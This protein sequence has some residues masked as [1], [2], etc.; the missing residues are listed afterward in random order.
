MDKKIDY[1]D[2]AMPI[3]STTYQCLTCFTRIEEIHD[4]E[5][6]VRVIHPA[7][8]VKPMHGRMRSPFNLLGLRNN[9]MYWFEETGALTLMDSLDEKLAEMSHVS[10]TVGE[11]LKVVLANMN[12]RKF[13]SS[14]A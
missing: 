11:L 7:E 10:D 4:K 1:T 14:P 13:C 8:E 12:R 6:L 2:P 9:F 3:Y 5:L